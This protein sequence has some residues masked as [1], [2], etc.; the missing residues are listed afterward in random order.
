MNAYKSHV[1][2]NQYTYLAIENIIGNFTTSEETF[3][4]DNGV[5]GEMGLYQP[6]IVS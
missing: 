5:D 1:N 4:T 6:N 2:S 3:M